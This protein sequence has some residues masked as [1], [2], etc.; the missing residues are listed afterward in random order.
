MKPAG[1]DYFRAI[2]KVI[3][4]GR[5]L[6]VCAAEVH[7]H[8]GEKETVIAIMQA[9]MIAVRDHSDLVD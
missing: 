9:T 1:G 7:A 4:A 5:T 3:R 8:L 6:T 2:G